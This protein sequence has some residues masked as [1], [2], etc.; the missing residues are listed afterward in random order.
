MEALPWNREKRDC[1]L[2]LP[3][4]HSFTLSVF[5]WERMCCAFERERELSIQEVDW[6]SIRYKNNNNS[7]NNN[8]MINKKII[9]NNNNNGLPLWIVILLGYKMDRVLGHWR[10]SEIKS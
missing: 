9:N 8:N 7:I 4:Q 6:T 2:R 10:R 5:C 3:L 1:T